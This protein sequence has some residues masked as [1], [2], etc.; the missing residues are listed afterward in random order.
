MYV[1]PSQQKRQQPVAAGPLVFDAQTAPVRLLGPRPRVSR[2][3]YDE[4]GIGEDVSTNAVAPTGSN[5][6]SQPWRGAARIN[7]VRGNHR[8]VR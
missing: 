4:M 5:I 2:V 1:R 3:V 7:R 6:V 8:S